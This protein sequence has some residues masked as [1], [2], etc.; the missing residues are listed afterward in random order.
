M[1]KRMLKKKE[2]IIEAY[3]LCY[4]RS[5]KQ[6]CDLIIEEKDE[7]DFMLIIFILKPQFKF[8]PASKNR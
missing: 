8:K 5:N 6:I 2:Y 4:S 3:I 1:L 7:S